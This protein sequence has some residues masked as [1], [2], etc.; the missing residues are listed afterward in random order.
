MQISRLIEM[1]HILLDKRAVTAAELAEHFEISVRTVYRDI[2]ALS[3]AGFPV[4][5][6]R[7]SQRDACGVYLRPVLL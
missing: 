6:E 2:E 7:G 1:I 4:Y 3:Q 5:A